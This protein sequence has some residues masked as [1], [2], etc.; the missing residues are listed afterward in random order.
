[1]GRRKIGLDMGELKSNT[2]NGSWKD[3]QIIL[4]SCYHFV[5]P[6]DRLCH[7][8]EIFVKIVEKL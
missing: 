2:S 8:F 7:L 3:S 5:R 6:S 4:A 1:V